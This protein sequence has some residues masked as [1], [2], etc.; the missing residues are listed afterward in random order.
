[1]RIVSSCVYQVKKKC[2]N[3]LRSR[4]TKNKLVNYAASIA[5]IYRVSRGKS[6]F[7]FARLRSEFFEFLSHDNKRQKK[8]K[9]S[10]VVCT[11]KKSIQF[12]LRFD[13]AQAN[14]QALF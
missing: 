6:V 5:M 12:C 11:C 13:I 2:E 3:K 9:L 4:I 7:S 8:S 10:V 1:M 14:P